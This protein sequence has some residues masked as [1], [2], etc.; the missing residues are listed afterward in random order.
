MLLFALCSLAPCA[1]FCVS[2]LEVECKRASG[3]ASSSCP[4]SSCPSHDT[5]SARPRPLS[6][7]CPSW[8]HTSS[9]RPAPESGAV[10][11]AGAAPADSAACAAAVHGTLTTVSLFPGQRL[12]THSLAV[13]VLTLREEGGLS[14]YLR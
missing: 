10:F 9:R 4:H 8:G 6:R 5:P 2:G 14:P 1:F 11:G 3:E 12:Q 7:A 13:L